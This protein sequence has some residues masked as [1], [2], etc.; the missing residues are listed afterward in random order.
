[1]KS[2]KKLEETT[3]WKNKSIGEII[4]FIL[5]N[6]HAYTRKQMKRLL[7]FSGKSV[8]AYGT[9]HPELLQLHM[10]LMEMSEELEGHMSRE[11]KEVF[12]FLNKLAQTTGKARKKAEPPPNRKAGDRLIHI[13]M[14]EHGM[15]GEEWLEIHRLTKDFN[16]PPDAGTPYKSLYRGLKE[17]EDDLHQHIHIENNVL[18]HRIVEMGFLN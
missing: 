1:M 3:R 18:F 16:T 6:H 7:G 5:I 13:L 12:P 17:M 8:K 9:K 15:T 10:I 4:D 14:W 11:E 2:E